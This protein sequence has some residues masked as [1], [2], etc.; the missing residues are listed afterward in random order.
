MKATAALLSFASVALAAGI[1]NNV[2]SMN[3]NIFDKRNCNGNNCNR[4]ITGTR[5]GL[6]ASTLREADCTSFLLTTV[7]PLPVVSTVWLM[8]SSTT[9]A[10]VASPSIST[11]TGSAVPTDAV[12]VSPSVLPS[13][14]T[15]CSSPAA[16]A[17]A[18]S[19]WGITGVVTLAAT[20]TYTVTSTFT[21]CAV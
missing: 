13:Y 16:Y 9:L 17:S 1:S 7:T 5:E 3:D 20:P 12:T 8:A 18:C 19:C 2:D 6:A 10:T 21:P 15:E 4:A 11:S 14:A